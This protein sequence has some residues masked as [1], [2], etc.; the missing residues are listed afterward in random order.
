MIVLFGLGL[1]A[2][3]LVLWNFC[4]AFYRRRSTVRFVFICMA[5]GWPVLLCRELH[6]LS[7]SA[8]IFFV[9]LGVSAGLA[10]AIILLTR[11]V[12]DPRVLD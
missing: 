11:W 12:T 10:S 2:W 3:A 8:A 5:M 9:V 6:W 7:R 4:L 1:L